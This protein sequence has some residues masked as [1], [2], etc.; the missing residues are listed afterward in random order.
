VITGLSAAVA[1]ALVSLGVDFK[2]LHTEGDLQGGLEEAE[3]LLGFR[4]V[5]TVGEIPSPR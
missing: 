1:Q 5:K 4:L 2:A 3:K